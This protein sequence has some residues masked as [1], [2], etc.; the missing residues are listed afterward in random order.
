MLLHNAT[1]RYQQ[2]SELAPVLF[3][4]YGLSAP[5]SHLIGDR[6]FV[7]TVKTGKCVFTVVPPVLPEALNALNDV[8]RRGRFPQGLG[9]RCSRTTGKRRF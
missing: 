6:L 4:F 5:S 2:S 1:K 7:R 9:R 8:L 3:D